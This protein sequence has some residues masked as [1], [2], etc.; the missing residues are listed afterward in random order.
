MP[1]LSLDPSVWSRR[2]VD[3]FRACDHSHQLSHFH[4]QVLPEWLAAAH[5][6]RDNPNTVLSALS[7]LSSPGWQAHGSGH[8]TKGETEIC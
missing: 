3:D 4:L 6:H 7:L 5:H 2:A 8:L 1:R